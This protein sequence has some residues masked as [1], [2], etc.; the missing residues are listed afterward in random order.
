M[1]DKIKQFFEKNKTKQIKYNPNLIK[2]LLRDHVN[3]KTDWADIIKLNKEKKYQELFVKCKELKWNIEKHCQKEEDFL[4][5]FLE[6]TISASGSA[7]HNYPNF[8]NFKKNILSFLDKYSKEI[9]IDENLINKEIDNVTEIMHKTFMIE[10][11]NLFKL[12]EKKL[13]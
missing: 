6:E 12:Y 4:Y 1:L 11:L 8:D 5:K 3:I 2:E 9:N 7:K 13:Y 10:E